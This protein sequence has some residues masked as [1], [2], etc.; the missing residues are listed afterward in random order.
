MTVEN[1]T[2]TAPKL[3]GEI[4]QTN[5][6]TIV[7]LTGAHYFPASRGIASHNIPLPEHKGML[8]EQDL[9]EGLT[10][11]VEHDLRIGIPFPKRVPYPVFAVASPVYVWTG[12][13]GDPSEQKVWART[14]CY[15]NE[16]SLKQMRKWKDVQPKAMIMADFDCA[17]TPKNLKRITD[18]LRKDAT[19][20]RWVL[21]TGNSFHLVD[22]ELIEPI[23]YPWH[24]G[25][26]INDFASTTHPARRNIIEA[27]GNE[28]QN[29]WY[30]PDKLK[31]WTKEVLRT[32]KHYDDTTDDG[33][34]FILDIRHAAHSI[35]E[36]LRFMINEW[37]GF[38]FLRI[39]G[40]LSSDRPPVVVAR[41]RPRRNIELL[42]LS[43]L[44][45]AT[46]QMRLL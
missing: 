6:D 27:F 35:D 29:H 25:K 3:W 44:R 45:S 43:S 15:E 12:D 10:P 8:L 9:L 32:F 41:Q 13:R 11:E 23:R 14:I 28:L 24:I 20:S 17:G 40:K 31:R 19:K 34:P 7:A 2:L 42:N 46:R 16:A 33:M 37:G 39:S 36:Y 4:V 5:P 22:E 21:H 18:V 26:L 1:V 30:H 38:G